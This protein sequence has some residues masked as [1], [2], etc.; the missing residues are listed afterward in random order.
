MPKGTGAGSVWSGWGPL[1]LAG[2]VLAGVGTAHATD[3]YFSHG[4]GVQQKGAGG[5][6]IAS[7]RDSLSIASNPANALSLGNRLDAGVEL[8]RPDR[9][10]SITGNAFGADA[11]YDGNATETFFI[12]EFGYVRQL[13]DKVAVGVA[14][15]GNGGMN[16]DYAS[17]P[18]AR[19]GAAGDAGVNFEQLF[20]TPTI[21]FR[22]GEEQS[23]GVSAIIVGQAFRAKGIAPFAAA[24]SDPANFTNRSTDTAFGLGVRVGWLGQLTDR[25]R[26]GAYYQSRAYTQDFEKYRG[27]FADHGAFDVPSNFGIG[28]NY[29]LS[30]QVS[31][32]FDVRRINFSEVEAVGNT[33]APLLVSGI[34]FGASGGPGFGWEDSTSYKFGV[35]WR[36]S[37]S[38]TLRAGYD[39][40]ENPIPADQTFL[41]ILAP[42]VVEDQ[43]TIGATWALN[44]RVEL[45]GYVLHAPERTVHGS[46]SIPPGAPPGFGGGEANIS[47]G[48]TA[49]GFAVGWHY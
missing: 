47:L 29:A 31:L 33:L 30:D 46:N 26:A 37:P 23:I 48:E 11:S 38:L 9:S 34:P 45:S 14:I 18:F 17:N 25:L 42:G 21:A 32:A 1:L 27:L 2:W 35:D 8:F 20:I 40:A 24:S 12:P 10:A 39:H 22:V 7:P 44:D 36:V 6:A 4:A 43:Y 41:N 13:N 5:T 28:L 3:G 49:A 19:F 16:T 15:Y